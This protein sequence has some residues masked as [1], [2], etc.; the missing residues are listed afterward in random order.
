MCGDMEVR[1]ISKSM[2]EKPDGN[3]AVNLSYAQQGRRYLLPHEVRELPGDGMLVFAEGIRGVI[4]AGRRPY[5]R[6]PEFRGMYD[7]DPYHNGNSHRS[8]GSAG[9]FSWLWK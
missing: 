2:S 4:R 8:D 3:L 5:Y 7:P 1:G 6:S 9:F